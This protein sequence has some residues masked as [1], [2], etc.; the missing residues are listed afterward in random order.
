MWAGN[1]VSH[2]K[3]RTQ[4]RLRVLENRLRNLP[5]MDFHLILQNN[6]HFYTKLAQFKHA[7]IRYKMC[8][9]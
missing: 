3:G 4:A 9:I 1:L 5:Y 6:K 7:M 2:L 8:I